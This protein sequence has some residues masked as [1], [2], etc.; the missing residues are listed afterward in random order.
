[1]RLIDKDE[2]ILILAAETHELTAYHDREKVL[3]IVK[4]F[5]EVDVVGMVVEALKR[6]DVM[7][8]DCR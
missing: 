3:G 4:T 7:Q 6:S 5:P 1:M 8:D 2:L